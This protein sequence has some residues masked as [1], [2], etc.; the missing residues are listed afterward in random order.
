MTLDVVFGT[1]TLSR[2]FR[3]LRDW[4]SPDSILS[5]LR[6]DERREAERAVSELTGMGFLVEEG[7]DEMAV[8]LRRRRNL[9]EK[10][11]IETLYILPTDDCNFSCRYCYVAN[12]MKGKT[13]TYMTEEIAT[14]S[15]R[16]FWKHSRSQGAKSIV[17]HGG[18][19]TLNKATVISTIRY[20]RQ[21]AGD[22]A[23]PNIVLFTNGSNMSAGFAEFLAS[24]NVFVVFSID[25]PQETHDQMRID[26]WG[27][28][29]FEEV[30]RGYD[31]CREKGCSIGISVVV[32][33][34]NVAI[35]PDV[36]NF[37]Y[38][39][40]SPVSIGI[41][42]LHL[43]YD[44][45]SPASI[46]TTEL[47]NQMIRCFETCRNQGIYVEHLLRRIRPFVSKTPRYKDCPSC[48]GKILA[49]PDGR[50]GVCEAFWGHDKYYVQNSTVDEFF[51]T[52]IFKEWNAR[53]PLNSESCFRCPGISMCGGG[54]PYDAHVR[55][56]SIFATDDDRCK[57][58]RI[59][60]EWLIWD[61]FDRSRQEFE[62]RKNA[63]FVIPSWASRQELLGRIHLRPDGMQLSDYSSYG[64]F[65]DV[66]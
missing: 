7:Q 47:T 32:G 39:E 40:F 19:P 35:L 49:G 8:P 56:G 46:D 24:N 34:H 4:S 57:Q 2:I 1:E 10:R 11:D 31:L 59:L 14:R 54:C 21:T 18:E 28:G 62:S 61:L 22:H 38:R 48:G 27:R 42:T 26:R 41:S 66:R 65:T 63:L 9:L 60:L 13:K 6:P 29:T 5:A 17:F 25:G 37:I 36:V 50:I 51:E 33:Q 23:S 52:S 45:R 15:V 12:T 20:A 30:C 58:T 64:E 16:L 55:H 44:G 3:Q 53:F 43:L